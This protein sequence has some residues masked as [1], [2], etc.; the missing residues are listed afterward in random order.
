MMNERSDN[1]NIAT[2]NNASNFAS[3]VQQDTSG[4]PSTNQNIPEIVYDG[5]ILIYPEMNQ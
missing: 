3:S 5:V 1:D 4:R 2:E